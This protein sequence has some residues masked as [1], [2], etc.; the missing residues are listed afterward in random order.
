[1]ITESE[2]LKIKTNEYSK[3][4][5]DVSV[6]IVN[7]NS[8]KYLRETV[9]SLVENSENIA[10]ELII[11]DNDSNRDD[12]SY[13]YIEHLSETWDN[14][15]FVECGENLGFAK[16]NN[17]CMKLARGRNFLILNP[18]VIMHNNVLRILCDYLDNNN[19]VGMVG[20]KVLNTD[21]SFQQPC[22][23]GK[24]YPK[25]TLFHLV[26]LAKMFPNCA[27]FNGYAMWNVDKNSINECWALS[28]ACMMV[29]RSLFEQI[30]GMDELF[31]MYQEETDWGL[32][33]KE[34]GKT[35]VYNPFAVVTHYKGVTVQNIQAK[36]VLIFTQSM[37]K[38]FR[39]HFWNR[40][41]VVQKMFWTTLI[42]GNF[43]LKY[44][45]LRVFKCK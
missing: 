23:R 7:W 20:P 5:F 41:N 16:A 36:S 14:F 11:A 38:F 8:G 1:M 22:L 40:Y 17:I 43:F 25:D 29:S 34:V 9:E 42:W 33:T 37:M 32:R 12:E 28:G 44:V 4:E 30:G 10:Y 45:K 27:A 24:P 26:G 31:F 15:T 2:K 21:G 6:I 35:V 3:N 19:N 18:D 39:K 13:K